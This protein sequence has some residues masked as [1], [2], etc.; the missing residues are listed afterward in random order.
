[1]AAPPLNGRTSLIGAAC[2]GPARLHG[3]APTDPGVDN[4]RDARRGVML[5]CAEHV[6]GL[7]PVL[8]LLMVRIASFPVPWRGCCC[9]WVT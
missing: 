9:T 6:D 2:Q 3:G 8:F 5:A 1:M 4:W 7:V